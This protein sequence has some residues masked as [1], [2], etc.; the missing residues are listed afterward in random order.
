MSNNN[1][2]EKY[3]KYKFKYNHLLKQMGGNNYKYYLI[4]SIYHNK[5]KNT[6]PTTVSSSSEQRPDVIYKDT[7]ITP[8]FIFNNN[9]MCNI[10][11]EDIDTNK[12]KVVLINI[13]NIKIADSSIA[14]DKFYIFENIQEVEKLIPSKKGKNMDETKITPNYKLTKEYTE[15]S[16]SKEKEKVES[17]IEEGLVGDSEDTSLE[18]VIVRNS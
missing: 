18:D 15:L 1:Y 17:V 11:K 9:I 13:K 3:L 7:E 16:P 12:D 5:E 2:E 10:K 6:D 4:E 14:D 8:Q